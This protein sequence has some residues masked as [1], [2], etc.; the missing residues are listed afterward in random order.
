MVDLAAHHHPDVAE[1]VRGF[2]LGASGS[3][4]LDGGASIPA[5]DGAQFH[6]GTPRLH[7][8]AILV[9]G[10]VE[11]GDLGQPRKLSRT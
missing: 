1:T 11:V 2:P 3:T 4:R 10:V 7:G 8:E 9:S 6:P 5:L